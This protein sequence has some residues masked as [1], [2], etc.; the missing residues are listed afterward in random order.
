MTASRPGALLGQEPRSKHEALAR[1]EQA[2][3]GCALERRRREDDQ[4]APVA[5][6]DYEV[7]QVLQHPGR[8]RTRAEWWGRVRMSQAANLTAGLSI[9]AEHC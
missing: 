5:Q 1:H 7:Q 8:L 2:R 6:P 3:E 9:R 4:I